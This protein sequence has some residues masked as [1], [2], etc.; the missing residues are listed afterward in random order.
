MEQLLKNIGKLIEYNSLKFRY[1]LY[2]DENKEK[3]IMEHNYREP[4]D[5]TSYSG[6]DVL[7]ELQDFAVNYLT[8]CTI[9]VAKVERLIISKKQIFCDMDDE[10]FELWM[11]L[12]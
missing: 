9:S 8:G 1:I 4:K 6:A 3:V 10:T 5:I 2:I 7:E 12:N 11:K